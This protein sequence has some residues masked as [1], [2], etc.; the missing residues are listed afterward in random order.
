MLLK[1]NV[2]K[3]PF[4]VIKEQ[5]LVFKRMRKNHMIERSYKKN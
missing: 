4:L 1:I 5:I 3:N 2:N